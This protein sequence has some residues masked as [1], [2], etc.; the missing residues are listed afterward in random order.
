MWKLGRERLFGLLTFGIKYMFSV[1]EQSIY[2]IFN[3]FS[4]DCFIVPPRNDE[5][6]IGGVG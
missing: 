1:F 5:Y 6:H 3:R 4:I 2:N